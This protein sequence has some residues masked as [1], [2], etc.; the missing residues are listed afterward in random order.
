M[1]EALKAND[2]EENTLVIFS[3][4][5]GPEK[6]AFERTRKFNHVSMGEL[7]GLKRDIWEGG[8]RVPFIVKWPGKIKPGTVSDEVINQVDIMATVASIVDYKLPNKTAV[9]SYNLLPVLKGEDYNKPLREA[10][11]QNTFAD[12]YALRQG[13]WVYLNTYSGEHSKTPSWFNEK[14]GYKEAE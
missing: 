6:Y 8:H 7:R 13:D 5:N 3:A 2:L 14:T 1:F 10:T 4:D 9:D 11:V 12:R